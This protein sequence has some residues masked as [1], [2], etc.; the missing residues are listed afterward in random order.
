MKISLL[1]SFLTILVLSN[2]AHSEEPNDETLSI[3]EQCELYGAYE[4]ENGDL[5]ECSFNDD[6]SE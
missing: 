1:I 3:E 4:D 6:D 5:I 2:V